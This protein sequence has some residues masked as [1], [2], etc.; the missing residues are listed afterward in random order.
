MCLSTPEL[1]KSWI[2]MSSIFKLSNSSS[3]VLNLKGALKPSLTSDSFTL[4]MGFWN[5]TTQRSKQL[6]VKTKKWWWFVWLISPVWIYSTWRRKQWARLI[7]TFLL[8]ITVAYLREFWAKRRAN[9]FWSVNDV[10]INLI[11]VNCFDKLKMASKIEV[12]YT[13]T[14]LNT[15][16]LFYLS[17]YLFLSE[18]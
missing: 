6:G 2:W 8:P 12:M 4:T 7:P 17:E 13:S 3:D 15:M 14:L 11:W 5:C 18:N 1:S 9:E 10:Q 16:R